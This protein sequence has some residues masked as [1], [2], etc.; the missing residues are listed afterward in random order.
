LIAADCVHRVD[1]NMSVATALKVESLRPI[2]VK[3]PD[4]PLNDVSW[5]ETLQANYKPAIQ[6]EVPS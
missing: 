1:W 5:R 6:E 3:R 2:S 4:D